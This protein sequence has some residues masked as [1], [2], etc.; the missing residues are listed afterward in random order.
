MRLWEYRRDSRCIVVL[1][2]INA[3]TVVEDWPVLDRIHDLR[4]SK[5]IMNDVVQ[6]SGAKRNLARGTVEGHICARFLC[7]SQKAAIFVV[8][9]SFTHFIEAWRSAVIIFSPHN[10]RS[11]DF[12]H[13]HGP[14]F[15]PGHGRL[16]R[17]KKI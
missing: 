13:E 16:H 10:G 17:A 12:G 5:F 9:G 6:S 11:G 4:G 14:R 3:Q 2:E 1:N 8:I 7:T 15:Y